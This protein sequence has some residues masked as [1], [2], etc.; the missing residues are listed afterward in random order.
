MVKYLRRI[1]FLLI[2]VLIV[3]CGSDNKNGENVATTEEAKNEEKNIYIKKPIAELLGNANQIQYPDGYEIFPKKFSDDILFVVAKE[4]SSGK[5]F[6]SYIGMNDGSFIRIKEIEGQAEYTDI[7]VHEVAKNIIFYEL[8]DKKMFKSEYYYYDMDTSVEKKIYEVDSIPDI[9]YTYAT[10]YKDSIIFS[11]YTSEKI[12][13]LYEYNIK[14]NSIKDIEKKNSGYPIIYGDYLYYIVTDKNAKTTE[15]IKENISSYEK[16]SV[17]KLTGD[18]KFIFG[19]YTNG[20]DIIYS[21]YDNNEV[22]FYRGKDFSKMKESYS[23]TWAE[24]VEYNKDYLVFLGDNKEPNRI[25]PQFY[26]VDLK[27]NIDY[28]YKDSIIHIS[29]KGIFNVKFKIDENNIDKGKIFNNNN[30]VMQ[31]TKY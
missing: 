26:I 5:R 14:R 3:G 30:S 23:T 8:L 31:Y 18:K 21:T 15:I 11:V 25:K 13:K 10:F 1:I 4:N 29:E 27:N 9:H 7:I 2:S 12:Y 19:L 28:I 6:M 17:Y 24:S 20:E 22:V 16:E